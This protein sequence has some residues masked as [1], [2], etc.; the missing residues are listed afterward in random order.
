MEKNK[1]I[2]GVAAIYPEYKKWEHYSVDLAT[3]TNDC[4]ERSMNG[5]PLPADS[6][7]MTAIV[8][9]YQWISKGLPI[10]AKIPWLGLKPSKAPMFRIRPRGKKYSSRNAP[11]AM[12]PMARAPQSPRPS[13]GP[14]PSTT[15]PA[16]PSPR[17]CR[18]LPTSTCPSAILT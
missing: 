7:E 16:W 6:K 12:V 3:R 9:Y 5:K 10:Y 1:A 13:G 15:G 14:S 18:R 4:F 11:F 2:F 17:T 8:T